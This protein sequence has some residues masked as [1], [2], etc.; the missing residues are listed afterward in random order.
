MTDQKKKEATQVVM[1]AQQLFSKR[2]AEGMTPDERR[3]VN[4]KVK[5]ELGATNELGKEITKAVF[6][7]V[8]PE[9]DALVNSVGFLAHGNL[10]PDTGDTEAIVTVE[11]NACG[12]EHPV[13]AISF[14]EML[15][16]P[17]VE[18]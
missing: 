18:E 8:C 6:N 15:S 1:K 11:C 13:M 12:K 3:A 2:L 7:Y 14:S 10:N 5:E 17:F 9:T 4:E 16:M